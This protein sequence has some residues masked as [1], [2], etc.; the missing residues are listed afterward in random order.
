MDGG[1]APGFQTVISQHT[2]EG[3]F[4]FWGKRLMGHLLP[5][6]RR[7]LVDSEE[8]PLRNWEASE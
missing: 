1:W 7:S 2:R 6:A 5:I 4:N 3:D 8:V